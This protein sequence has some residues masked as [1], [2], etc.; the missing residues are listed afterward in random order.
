MPRPRKSLGQHFLRDLSFVRRIVEAAEIAPGD[1]VV[2]I[3]PGRGALSRRLA[4]VS[5]R[6]V[7]VELDASLADRLRETFAD[8]PTVTVITA[9]A[10]EFDPET[11]AELTGRPY[12]VVGNLPY[13]AAAPIVR[14]FLELPRKPEMLVVMVQR[15]VAQGMAARPGDMGLLSVG[16]QV[17]AEPRIVCHVP[18]RAFAPPPKV[19]SSV[20]ALKVRPRPAVTV[21]PLETFFDLVR[22]GFAAP[23]KTLSNSLSVGL[24]VPAPTLA[25][26]LQSTGIDPRRRPSTLSIPEWEALCVAWRLAGSPGRN[27]RGEFEAA[28]EPPSAERSTG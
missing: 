14:R 1:T 23:R 13:Y 6:L 25:P 10:R 3:G 28:V 16:V 7:L 27:T 22:A 15:E 20:V 5:P 24:R 12:R 19:H 4:E 11:V 8:R 18:P 2:E 9:D 17:Y 21:E 26:V